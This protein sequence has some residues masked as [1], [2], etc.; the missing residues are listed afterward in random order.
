[1]NSAEEQ[2]EIRQLIDEIIARDERLLSRVD[3]AA[4]ELV[5]KTLSVEKAKQIFAEVTGEKA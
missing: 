2:I 1:M 4:I 5:I 3:H